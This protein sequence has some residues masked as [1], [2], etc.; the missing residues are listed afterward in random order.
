M[1]RRKFIKKTLTGLPLLLLSSSFLASCGEDDPE[2]VQP[3]GKTV[4]VV[5]GGISGLAGV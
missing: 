5:G 4:V 3:N 2:I 1:Q